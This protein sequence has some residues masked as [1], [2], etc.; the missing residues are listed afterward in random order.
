MPDR[1]DN[2]K[3]YSKG[4][5][6]RFPPQVVFV[7]TEMTPNGDVVSISGFNQAFPDVPGYGWCGEH[8]RDV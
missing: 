1:C 2:C 8:K 6:R 3:F 7:P 4:H 5:C